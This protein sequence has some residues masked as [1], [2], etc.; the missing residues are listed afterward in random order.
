MSSDDRD[1]RTEVESSDDGDPTSKGEPTS[2]G[3]AVDDEHSEG[4]ET[5]ESRDSGAGPSSW[6]SEFDV[7]DVDVKE[8]LRSALE[9]PSTGKVKDVTREVQ[10]KIREASD[11]HFYGDGWSTAT[12]PRATFLVTS[13]LI[14]IVVVLAW[15]L[16]APT[17]IELVR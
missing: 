7:D 6:L 14:L 16:L 15:L 1:D 10:K 8:Y 13:V 2:E 17:G 4:D 5:A 12:A 9:P 3:D 11:G